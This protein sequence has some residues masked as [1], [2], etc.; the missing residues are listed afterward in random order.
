[1][2]EIINSVRMDK[3]VLS[4]ASL[5]DESDDR[6]Y[7]AEKSPEERWAAMEYLR[8]INYGYDPSTERLQ[9]VLT[10]VDLGES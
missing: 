8:V 1:M 3:T 2:K 7:W 9:R 10:V 6:S 5:A 4:V